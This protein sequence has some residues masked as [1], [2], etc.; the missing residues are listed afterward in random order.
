M[1]GSPARPE[2]ARQTPMWPY[3]L[4]GFGE[5]VGVAAPN[6]DRFL[7][8]LPESLHSQISGVLLTL[9]RLQ[10]ALLCEWP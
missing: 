9:I 6:I 2:E 7:G 5:G 3:K 4:W 8:P 1:T 10:H